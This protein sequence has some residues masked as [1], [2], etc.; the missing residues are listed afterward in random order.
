LIL[1]SL[2]ACNSKPE[3]PECHNFQCT[4]NANVIDL[5]IVRTRHNQVGKYA[6][7]KTDSGSRV[8]FLGDCADTLFEGVSLTA[9][10]NSASEIPQYVKD[11][12]ASKRFVVDYIPN[13]IVS[14]AIDSPM[15]KD[16]GEVYSRDIVCF[17]NMEYIEASD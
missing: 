9:A 6:L 15:N 1:F 8:L 10:Y 2:A 3:L 13:E 16:G 12:Y 4:I 11:F 5:Q 14:V 17:E 7:V